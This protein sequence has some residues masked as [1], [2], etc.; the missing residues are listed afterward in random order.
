MTAA[1]PF[2][3]VETRLLDSRYGKEFPVPAYA[4]AGSAGLDLRACLPAPV[5]IAAGATALVGSGIALSIRDAGYM[6]IAVARSGLG[7]RHGVVLANTVGVID[8]DYQG[9]IQI[10]LF[11]RGPDS[12]T[13]VPGDRICQLI[14]VPV[15][16]ANL[17]IVGAFSE[18]T[19]RGGGGFGSTG[20][21]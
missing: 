1:S 12:Y 4:T 11:N 10:A 13:V 18:S 14:I 20:R 2:L 16:Q 9:E 6:A 7:V 8:S 19:S 21:R 5:E 17:R 3:D 15:V